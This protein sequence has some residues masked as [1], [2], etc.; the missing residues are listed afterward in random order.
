[1]SRIIKNISGDTIVKINSNGDMYTFNGT[2]LG[3]KGN[4]RV[5]YNRHGSSTS[6]IVV[7]NSSGK[8]IGRIKS[9]GRVISSDYGT[10]YGTWK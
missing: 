8:V 10:T 2:L 9:D 7:T 5:L 4:D 6:E 3:R 1:M